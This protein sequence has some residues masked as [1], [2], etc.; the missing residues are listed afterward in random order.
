MLELPRWEGVKADAENNLRRIE[1]WADAL[2][3]SG[4]PQ[5]FGAD[6]YHFEELTLAEKLKWLEEFSTSVWDFRSGKER[7]QAYNPSLTK[8]QLQA[9]SETAAN[10]GLTGSPGPTLGHYDAVLLTGGM[11]RAGIVKPRFLAELATRG[12]DWGSAVFLG[13]SRPFGGDE[14]ELA[15][16]LE[17]TGEN[18]IDAMTIG[19]QRAFSLDEPDQIIEQGAGF[20]RSERR[21]WRT[22]SHL[23]EVMAAP[24]SEPESRRANTAD[25]LEFWVRNQSGSVTVLVITTSVYVPYQGAVAVEILGVGH[26]I[27]VETIAVSEEANNL[28]ALT[29]V[30]EPKHQLQELRS[31]IHG[32]HRLFARLS[33]SDSH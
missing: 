3:W 21:I 24:S 23:F 17:I 28:G 4:L 1:D 20:A 8:S 10:L 26:G 18:E 5:A 2:F 15:R 27:G 30:F 29:Q 19:L 9:L 14:I 6:N 13:A 32:M 7:N 16:Q 12:L 31:A 11:V 25:T 33:D 22:K